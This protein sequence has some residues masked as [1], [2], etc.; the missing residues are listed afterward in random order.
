MKLFFEAFLV[1]ANLLFVAVNGWKV[2]FTLHPSGLV[3]L[4][5][6]LSLVHLAYFLPGLVRDYY[7]RPAASAPPATEA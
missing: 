2:A 6:V 5:L 1:F 3:Y 4:G 7:R